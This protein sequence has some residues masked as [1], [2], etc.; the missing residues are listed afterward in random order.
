ML[1]EKI[2]DVTKCGICSDRACPSSSQQRRVSRITT[3]VILLDDER[4]FQKVVHLRAFFGTTFQKFVDLHIFNHIKGDCQFKN[5][6]CS[7]DDE[8][9]A[10]IIRQSK[11][12]LPYIS[13]LRPALVNLPFSSLVTYTTF[14]LILTAS[15]GILHICSVP[16]ADRLASGFS[17]DVYD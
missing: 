6:Q 10:K 17:S 14:D 1:S 7:W 2:R 3:A 16:F 12:V 15:G 8:G 13:T 9:K 11:N 4:S 5:A